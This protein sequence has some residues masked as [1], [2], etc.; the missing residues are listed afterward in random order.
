MTDTQPCQPRLPSTRVTL[1]RHGYATSGREQPLLSTGVSS[2]SVIAARIRSGPQTRRLIHAFRLTQS[3]LGPKHP[4]V[5][6][7]KSRL[8]AFIPSLALPPGRPV[9]NLPDLIPHTGLYVF[10]IDEDLDPGDI[11]AALQSLAEYDHTLL[12]ARSTSGDAL[13]AIVAGPVAENPLQHKLLYNA[14]HEALPEHIRRHAAPAQ[15]NIN[16]TRILAHDPDCVLTKGATPIHVEIAEP[17]WHAASARH[18]TRRAIAPGAPPALNRLIIQSITE[19]HRHTELVRSALRSLPARHA[20]D[21]PTWIATAF[22]LAGGQH[23]HGP[24][25]RGKQLFAEWSRTSPRYEPGDEDAFDKA[26]LEWDGRATTAGIIAEAKA[27][28]WQPPDHLN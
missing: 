18:I 5:K 26:L 23:L 24:A 4:E 10:D 22:R 6:R 15:N 12:A 2:L 16:R 28:G 13:Y 21:Y 25:F 14:I 3:R 1:L 8:P 19:A 7:M 17:P 27:A 11:P 20:D 9:R